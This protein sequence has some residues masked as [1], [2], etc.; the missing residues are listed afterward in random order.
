[1]DHLPVPESAT[2]LTFRY[3]GGVYNQGQFFA[4]LEHPRLLAE[5]RDLSS[6]GCGYVGAGGE[7]TLQDLVVFYQTLSTANLDDGRNVDEVRAFLRCLAG[8]N[9][10]ADDPVR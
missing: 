2:P 8:S 1:M 6:L 5:L 4:W 9:A 10:G 7:I 3:L